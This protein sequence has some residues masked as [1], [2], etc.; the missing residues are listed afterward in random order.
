MHLIKPG[1]CWNSLDPKIAFSLMKEDYRGI[2]KSCSHSFKGQIKCPKCGSHNIKMGA[3]LL[4][5]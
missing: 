3:A 1:Q 4:L 2:C 5:I